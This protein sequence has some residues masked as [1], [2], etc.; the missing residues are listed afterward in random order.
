MWPFL[1]GMA[2]TQLMLGVASSSVKFER[3]RQYSLCR[4]NRAASKTV[5]G[6]S[7]RAFGVKNRFL[8]AISADAQLSGQLKDILNVLG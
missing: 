3:A 8:Y 6:A 5:M 7:N 4:L 1:F 2:T